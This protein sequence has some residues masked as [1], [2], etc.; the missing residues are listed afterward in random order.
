MATDKG[1]S[2]A[3]YGKAGMKDKQ[4]ELEQKD[5]EVLKLMNS[6]QKVLLPG[7]GGTELEEPMV[8][9]EPTEAEVV[10]PNKSSHWGRH[11]IVFG[12]DRHTRE[13]LSGYGGR[14]CTAAGSIDIVV[15]SGG[16]EPKHGLIV[17]PNFYTDA[18]RI[19]LSQRCDIDRYFSLPLDDKTAVQPSEN[20]SAIAIKADA[21]RVI[22]REGV[23][24]YSNA[25]TKAS[26]K[27]E[28]T[29]AQ[30]GDIQTRSGI[31]LIANMDVGPLVPLGLP[32]PPSPAQLKGYNK[33]QPMVR[34]ELLIGFLEDLLSD[35]QNLQQA[36]TDLSIAQ[37]EFNTALSLHTHEVVSAIP[38]VA[39]PDF[40]SLIPQGLKANLTTL[41]DTTIKTAVKEVEMNILTKYNWLKP[42]SP[43]YILS[44]YNKTN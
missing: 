41:K 19:Y 43:L 6:G 11:R 33:L 30:G 8:K 35:I 13:G 36:V 15:G 20:R 26:G 3:G 21:V 17:G 31:Y 22:G 2:F 38:G 7:Q 27:V 42:S 24:I 5:E 40:K 28:E 25:R 29:N 9:Y 23:R 39:L 16:P 32:G 18:A 10:T 1:R 34:G 44:K 4:K 37:I 14:G 12:R